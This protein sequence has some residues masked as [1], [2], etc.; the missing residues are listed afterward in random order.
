MR[1]RNLFLVLGAALCAVGA[2][3]A[4]A[5]LIEL[6]NGHVLQGDIKDGQT[7]DEGLAVNLYDTNGVVIVKWDHIVESRRRQLRRDAGIDLPEET[8]EFVAGHRV[9]LNSGEWAIGVAENPRDSAPLRMKTRTGVKEYD[10][11]MLAGKVEDAQID[12]LLVYTPEELYQRI[13]NETRPENAAAHKALAQRCMN[14]GAYE[15]AKE[16]LLAAKADEI[17]RDTQEGRAL[18]GMLRQCEVM[19]RSKGAQ[20]LVQ[21]IKLAMGQN[22]YND[23]L[24]VLNKLDADPQYK[25]DVIRKAISFDNLESRVVKARDT[26]F[27]KQIALDAYRVMDDLIEKKA[28]ER[29]PLRP[30]PGGAP[31]AAAVGTLAAARQW[32][33][34]ELFAQLWEKVGTDLGLT[35]DEMEKYWKARSVKTVR[36]ANYGTGSFIVVKKAATAKVPGGEQ[37]RR[38]PPSS[39]PSGKNAPQK[40]VKVDKPLT[41]EEWWEEVGPSDRKQWLIANFVETSGI[42][43]VIKADQVPCQSCGGAGFEKSTDSSGNENQTFCKQCNTSGVFRSVSYR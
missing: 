8:V 7:T 26:W 39:D 37:P 14:I 40:P 6:T 22:R 33:N 17:F 31:G 18:E 9:L 20:D 16:H 5:E 42:F 27:Q 15:H 24:N 41:D 36:K 34:R 1:N 23:A 25:D 13:F 43:D 29:K 21:Q 3:D 30:E 32:E 10:R 4:K 2:R 11:S 28:R 19:I 12:G 35:K 38:R